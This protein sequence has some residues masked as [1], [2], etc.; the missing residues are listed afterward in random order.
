MAQ[1]KQAASAQRQG[2]RKVAVPVT[3]IVLVA[4][5]LVGCS[6]VQRH[7]T[8]Q[9]TRATATVESHAA[10]TEQATQLKDVRETRIVRGGRTVI[11]RA[12]GGWDVSWY[13][14]Y[15]GQQVAEVNATS[16]TEANAKGKAEEHAGVKTDDKKVT[17]RPWWHW[18][19]LGIFAAAIGWAAFKAWRLKRRIT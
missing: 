8:S 4:V 17:A 19:V 14:D 5:A 18:V 13:Y 2:V 10:T 1:G 11:P 3:R 6:R 15:A 9:E 12:D 16:H 7:Q